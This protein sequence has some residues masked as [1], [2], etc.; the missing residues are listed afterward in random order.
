MARLM[1]HLILFG[2]L[3]V[4]MGFAS[5][6]TLLRASKRTIWATFALSAVYMYT[7]FAF[8]DSLLG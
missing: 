3:M 1:V 5:G 4:P 8:G 2:T 7:L 6:G